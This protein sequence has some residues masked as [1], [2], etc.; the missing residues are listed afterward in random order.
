MI[1]I[2]SK[3]INAVYF[4]KPYHNISN[5]EDIINNNS[6]LQED[7]KEY[8]KFKIET[9]NILIKEDIPYFNVYISEGKVK[10]EGDS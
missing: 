10:I 1:N 7:I 6:K 2:K 5:Y 3:K 9:I 8:E 4:W